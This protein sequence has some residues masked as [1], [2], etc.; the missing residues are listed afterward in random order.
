MNQSHPESSTPSPSFRQ[1]LQAGHNLVLPGIFNGIGARLARRTG[2]EAIFIGGFPLVG[3]RYGVPDIGLKGL[4]DMRPAVAEILAAC[5]LPALVD[6][7]DGYGDAKSAVHT[8][9]SYE[10]LGV[11]AVMVEDQLWPKRCGHLDGKRVVPMEDMVRKVRAMARSR[12]NSETFIIA[13]TDAREVH[14]LDDALRRAEA[15][16]EAGAD[17]LFIEA[18]HTEEELRII[19]KAFDVPQLANPLE[20]GKTP[21]LPPQ[22]Y[23]EMGF[24][25]L[26]YGLH[27]LMRTV[28]VMEEALQDLRSQR[29][30]MSYE[31]TAVSF[32]D[33]QDIVGL[34]DWLD[35]ENG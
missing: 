4:G 17:G 16:L 32:E 13:R 34:S 9:Q 19:G 10:R 22:A 29:F 5:D 27:L 24:R 18:P 14:G 2:Y 21:I 8:M 6:M 35:L 1:L 25:I 3:T 26:P 12:L 7:D 11:S 20:G 30:A 15:Y 33:Y 23:H 31:D 28:K